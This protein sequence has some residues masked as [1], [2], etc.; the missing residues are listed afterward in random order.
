MTSN[1]VVIGPGAFGTALAAVFAHEG[2]DAVTLLGRNAE[3]IEQLAP[4]E[5]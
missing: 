3:L 1:T 2:E 4:P 5:S